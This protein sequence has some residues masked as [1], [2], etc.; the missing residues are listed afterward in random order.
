MT[1][2]KSLVDFNDQPAS[3]EPT[4]PP[5]PGARVLYRRT[6]F[7]VLAP[8]SRPHPP[9]PPL[10]QDDVEADRHALPGTPAV[11]VLDAPTR[12]AA[13]LKASTWAVPTWLETILVFVGLVASFA[14][15]AINLFNYPHYEQDEGTYLMYAWAVT[16]GS[17]TNYPYGYG[18]PPLAW[19]Q[20]AAWVK[21]TGGFSTFGPAINTGL[22]M[23]LLFS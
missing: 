4:T 14:A 20:L 15:H 1:R 18:H 19:I 6:T 12:A 13:L 9:A 16:H 3:V 7:L 8:G 2:E 22:L 23:V 17:I 5:A 21:L 11:A 10:A